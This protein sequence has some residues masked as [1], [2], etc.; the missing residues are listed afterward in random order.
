[1]KKYNEVIT[2]LN[3]INAQPKIFKR[4]F[5][6]KLKDHPKDFSF[7]LYFLFDDLGFYSLVV[8]A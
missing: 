5:V 4:N 2:K 6:D 3:D 1:M 8:P 7:D